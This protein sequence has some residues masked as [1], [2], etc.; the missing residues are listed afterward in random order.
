MSREEIYARLNAVFRDVFDDETL[1]VS[2]TTTA[3]DIDDWDSLMNITLIAA[4]EAEFGIRFDM[5]S[6]LKMKS[7]GEMAEKISELTEN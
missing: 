3:D 6:A 1:T 5:K 7:A 4:V 2:D